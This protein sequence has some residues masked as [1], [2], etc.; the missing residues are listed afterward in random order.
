MIW[1]EGFEGFEGFEGVE[2]SE[3]PRPVWVGSGPV[4]ISAIFVTVPSFPPA[5]GSIF[6]RSTVTN[7]AKLGPLYW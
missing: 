2:G 1:V 6:Y 3:G 5:H 7:F 4:R